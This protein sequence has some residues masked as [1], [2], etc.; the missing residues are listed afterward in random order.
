MILCELLEKPYE[1]CTIR[2]T[3]PLKCDY[4]GKT[5]QRVK[6]SIKKLNKHINKD[7]CGSKDCKQKKQE[8]ICLLLYEQ[9]NYFQSNEFKVSQEKTNLEK[10]GIKEYFSSKEFQ[11]KRKESLLKKYGVESPLQS[12]ELKE[13]QKETCL[14][15]YGVK[16][17]SQTN[18]YIE[19]RNKTN[20]EKYGFENPM[21]NPNCLK[22]RNETN[23]ERYGKN[24]YTQTEQYKEDLKKTCLKKYGVDHPSKSKGNRD[25]AR[26]TNLEK[27]G[28]DNYAKTQEFKEKYYKTCME[29]YGVPNALCLKQNQIY[30]KTQKEIQDWLN[31]FG[32]NF[33]SNYSILK[34]Q[35]LDLYDQDLKIAIE[36]CGLFWHNEMSPQPRMRKYHYDKYLA[37]KK[38]NI[39]LLTIFEDEWKNKKEQCKN[40][41]LS[42]IGQQKEK[43]FARKCEIREATKKE[44]GD[45]CAKNH[46]QGKNGL[47][48]KFFVLINNNDIVG[49]MSFGKHHRG[50][51]NIIVLD[52]MCFKSDVQVVGGASKLFKKCKEWAIENK[53]N[54]IISWSDNRWS[55]GNVYEKLGFQ[56]AEELGP[57]YSY[58]DVKSPTKRLSKQSQ[59]KSN[60][61][62]PSNMTEKQWSTENGLARIWDCGKKRWEM[63]I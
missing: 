22:K 44:F 56:L 30:G 14:E 40:F 13:K 51:Q 55:I 37:C 58:V 52:R 43:L 29:K 10:Y 35:E 33:Q 31:S 3:I 54:K 53:Y 49:G 6:K 9:T 61:N 34:K 62:C 24:N 42:I 2:S 23:L 57:D 39:R 20:L 12:E 32:F 15:K 8:E 36:Y 50:N 59:K 63:K 17:Y 21:Q 27:Y 48:L 1:E 41:I 4:C 19:K 45:F 25:K 26:K 47:G 16:N 46:I 5:F 11:Q 28:K 60:T 38:E 18:E 7:S